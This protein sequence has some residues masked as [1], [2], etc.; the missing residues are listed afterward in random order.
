MALCRPIKVG[1]MAHVKSKICDSGIGSEKLTANPCCSGNSRSAMY[2]FAKLERPCAMRSADRRARH[3]NSGTIQTPLAWVVGCEPYIANP[4]CL[5]SAFRT[6]LRSV[7]SLGSSLC[8]FKNR[9]NVV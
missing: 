3:V 6:S 8:C 7:S 5:A 9:N 2:V 1:Y 4:I